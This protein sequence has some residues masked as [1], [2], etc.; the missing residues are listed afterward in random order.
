MCILASSW[1]VNTLFA[2]PVQVNPNLT[3]LHA[4]LRP[5]SK[6]RKAVKFLKES[7]LSGHGPHWGASALPS[8]CCPR[9]PLLGWRQRPGLAAEFL[10]GSLSVA[11]WWNCPLQLEPRWAARGSLAVEGVTDEPV[12]LW[13]V[14]L[15]GFGRHFEAPVL[16]G[17]SALELQRFP[18]H[19]VAVMAAAKALLALNHIKAVANSISFPQ[20]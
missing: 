11:L 16:W 13:C 6:H 20:G 12:C 3:M 14:C 15:K 8:S 5:Q 2:T 1:K 7:V 19:Q 18:C 10:L 4:F 9:L 17:F